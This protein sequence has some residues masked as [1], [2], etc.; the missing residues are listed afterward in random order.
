MIN[1]P[2]GLCHSGGNCLKE[3]S[4]EPAYRQKGYTG[5]LEQTDIGNKM[6]ITGLALQFYKKVGKEYRV[7]EK[8]VFEPHV[9]LKVMRN[10]SSRED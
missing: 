9:A 5:G 7:A 4:H 10:I 6:A 1:T 2:A 8:W 3:V